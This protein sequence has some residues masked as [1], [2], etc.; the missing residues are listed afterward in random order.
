MEKNRVV[1]GKFLFG[2]TPVVSIETPWNK[3]ASMGCHHNKFPG[4]D[5]CHFCLADT[6]VHP[7]A[8]RTCDN[9]AAVS[10]NGEPR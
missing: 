2:L 7:L 8:K 10:E 1:G 4:R 9:L 6:D 5:F 3:C